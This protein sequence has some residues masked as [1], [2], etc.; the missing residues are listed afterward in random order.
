MAPEGCRWGASHAARLSLTGTIRREAVLA[1]KFDR[2]VEGDQTG[3]CTLY[4][5]TTPA[6]FAFRTTWCRPTIQF[7]EIGKIPIQS[8]LQ[9]RTLCLNFV[10][11]CAWGGVIHQVVD[12]HSRESIATGF[13]SSIPGIREKKQALKTGM[14]DAFNYPVS[15]ETSTNHGP[16][17]WPDRTTLLRVC[18][19]GRVGGARIPRTTHLAALRI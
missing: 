13:W 12:T 9:T 3:A 1:D 18:A 8:H 19:N 2:S 16:A 17:L 11:G 4:P 5:L 6:S 14:R 15:K 7:L 10:N